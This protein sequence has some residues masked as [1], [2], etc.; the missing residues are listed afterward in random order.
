MCGRSHAVVALPPPPERES[1]PSILGG[2]QGLSA[3]ELPI[4]ALIISSR[5]FD[6]FYLLLVLGRITPYSGFAKSN[7]QYKQ[8]LLI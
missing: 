2:P 4:N 1:V 8:Q 7:K 5:L 6:I 3:F